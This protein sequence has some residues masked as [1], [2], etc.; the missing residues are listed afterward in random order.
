MRPLPL[1]LLAAVLLPPMAL[2]LVPGPGLPA[3]SVAAYVSTQ[4]PFNAS[5]ADGLTTG[6]GFNIACLYVHGGTTMTLTINDVTGAAIHTTYTITGVSPLLKGDLCRTKDI[7][8]PPSASEVYV[9]LYGTETCDGRTP[10]A[11]AGI[12]EADFH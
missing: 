11:V 6:V 1:A 12:I 2:A 4:A 9:V 5:C 3:P 10:G 7:A 8:L